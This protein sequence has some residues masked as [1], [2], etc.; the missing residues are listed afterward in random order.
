M[1][2]KLGLVRGAPDE[3]RGTTA[4]NLRMRRM[5]VLAAMSAAALLHA[6]DYS[7][8][9]DSQPRAEAPK[10]TV[11]KHK[12]APGKFYPG[13]PHDYAIYVPAQYDAAKP[14][15]FMIFMDGSGSLNNS[16]R[17]P[18]VFD[19]L[20][21]KHDLPPLIGIFV[22]PGV[23]PALSGD[24]QNRYE[25]VFEYDS[26]SDRYSRFLLEELIP[27][28]A[29]KY[30]LSKDPNDHA[31]SGVST[32]AVAAF[33]AAW[34]RPDQF[35]RVLSFIGTYVAMKGADGLPALIRKTEP[36]PIRIFLQEGKN[37]HIVPGQPWGTFYGGSWPINN[38]VMYQA[39]QSAGYD[40]KL[41]MG[42]EGHNMRQGAA[43]MPEALRWLWHGYPAPIA[44]QEP[45]V[46]SQPGW[47]P[48]GKVYS[49]VTAAQPWE[50]VGGTYGGV[51]SPAAGKD[52][53]MY[54]A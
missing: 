8:G 31:L 22:D 42:E 28:V 48:R 40:A 45:A 17:V 47:D 4:Y 5:M 32:G 27:E 43:I 44:V 35:H 23:L 1:S 13:T 37:D 20:I 12:L 2:R 46:M 38:E 21:A 33:M 41:V 39:L 16:V 24:A 29:K 49:T 53:T 18:V 26:L 50:Q 10:G 6:Q 11:T 3:R 34:N 52:G 30:N 9:P 36:K 54:F 19:N 14:A 7:L 25:R 51:A 15:P